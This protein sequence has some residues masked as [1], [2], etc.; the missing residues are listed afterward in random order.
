LPDGTFSS[1]FQFAASAS[2]QLADKNLTNREVIHAF[3]KAVA[4]V[5]MPTVLP[6]GAPPQC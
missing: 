6:S 4:L 2:R 5:R 3:F 1:Q